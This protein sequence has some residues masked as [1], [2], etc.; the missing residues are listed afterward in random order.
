MLL[1]SRRRRGEFSAAIAT[2]S[3]ARVAAHAFRSH[4]NADALDFRAAF[5][6]F[7]ISVVI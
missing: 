2:E 3:G 4:A 6:Q 7:A 1:S 5:A